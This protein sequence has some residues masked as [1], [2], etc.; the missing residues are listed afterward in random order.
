LEVAPQAPK[1]EPLRGVSGSV[2]MHLRALTRAG[3][4][5]QAWYWGRS[6]DWRNYPTSAILDVQSVSM[7]SYCGSPI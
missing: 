6:M 4:R 7:G 1:I 3:S 5:L 2:A